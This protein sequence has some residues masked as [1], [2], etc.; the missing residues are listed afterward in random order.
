MSLQRKITTML[1]VSLLSIGFVGGLVAFANNDLQYK[2]F[3]SEEFGFSI[4]YPEGWNKEYRDKKEDVYPYLHLSSTDP[5]AMVTVTVIELAEPTSLNELK[6]FRELHAQIF[7]GSWSEIK[8]EGFAGLQAVTARYKIVGEKMTTGE[9]GYE[10]W[11]R[12]ESKAKWIGLISN[13]YLYRISARAPQEEYEE[14]NKRYLSRI[15]DSFEL[16]ISQQ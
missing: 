8:I 11:E 10:K 2:T 14:V 15:I 4:S 9:D 16:E 12:S 1:I 13:G 3:T 6:R 7:N 5:R